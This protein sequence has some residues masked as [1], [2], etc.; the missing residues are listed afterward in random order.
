MVT[1]LRRSARIS[2]Q[3]MREHKLFGTFGIIVTQHTHIAN[4]AES[5]PM[6]GSATLHM[7]MQL[8]CVAQQVEF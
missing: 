1:A 5:M 2:L 6:Q 8:H 7:S 3:R 4:V